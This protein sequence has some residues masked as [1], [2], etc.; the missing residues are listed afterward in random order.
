MIDLNDLFLDF[1]SQTNTSQNGWWRPELDFE[2]AVNDASLKLWNKKVDEAE[3]AQRIIDELRPFLISKNIIVKNQN[4]FYG[5]VEIP[6]PN[7]DGTGDYGRFASARIL[8]AGS[9]CVPCKDVDQGKCSNGVWEDENKMANDYYNTVCEEQIE[10]IDNQRWPSVLT[11]LTRKPTLKKPK[12]TQINNLF[13]VAPREVSV[14]VFNY[15]TKP[16]YATFKYT[17]TP[18][19]LQNGSGD[20]IVYDKANSTP[21]EWPETVKN[22]LLD[23]IKDVYIGYSRDSQFQ[24]INAS[25][26][27]TAA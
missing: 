5:V 23:I 7:A 8:L 12:I 10:K 3:K 15:Y 4:S 11:H 22:E 16:Q 17:L 14:V 24:Q 2:R 21:L 19:N 13:Q 1:N 9:M 27:Q 20:V 25:Q 6:K 18:A 26:K